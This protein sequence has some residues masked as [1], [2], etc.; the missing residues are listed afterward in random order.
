MS[1][2]KEMMLSFSEQAKS[3]IDEEFEYIADDG[4]VHCKKCHDK[5]ETVLSIDNCSLKLRCTCRCIKE[6]R[7]QMKQKEQR[8]EIERLR[9]IC[10][11]ESRMKDW[12]FETDDRQNPKIS[13]ALVKYVKDFK[14]FKA[15]AKGIMLYGSVGTGKTYLSACVANALIDRGYRVLMTNFARLTSILQGKQFEDKQAYIDDLNRYALIVLDDLGAER[16]SDYMLE[17]VHSVI[18]SR[19]RSGLPMIITTNI[20]LND[21]LANQDE[22]Y[23]RIYDRIT[24]RC[25]P[26]EIKGESRRKT[27]I[28]KDF[29]SD[30]AKLGL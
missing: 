16:K 27:A 7:Q 25:I 9:D 26:I 23:T 10:F 12:T 6:Q 3:L 2:I 5:L 22:R 1:W 4:L 24:E 18:D 21:M 17:M 30:R 29:K 20:S 8:Q 14:T 13:D 28:I 19:Y 11:S 15:D